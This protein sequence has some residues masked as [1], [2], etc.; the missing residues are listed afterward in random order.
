YLQD[1]L[2]EAEKCLGEALAV[3][4]RHK[5]A[6]NNLGLVLGAQGR[7]PESLEAFQRVGSEAEAYA[8]LGYALAQRGEYEQSEKAYLRALTL[9]SG[10]RKAAAAML[11]V[12]DRRQHEQERGASTRAKGAEKSLAC[13]RHGRSSIHSPPPCPLRARTSSRAGRT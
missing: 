6:W 13:R 4:P 7:F 12:A 8:N 5:P 2:P 9:D 3:D 1:R 11:Q 10:L